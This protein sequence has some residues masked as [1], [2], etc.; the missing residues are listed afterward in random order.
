MSFH[1]V[2]ISNTAHEA[3]SA[4]PDAPVVVDSRRPSAFSRV[5]ASGLVGLVHVQLRLAAHLQRP[6]PVVCAD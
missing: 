2:P 5:L 4:L 1:T 6:A 3:N